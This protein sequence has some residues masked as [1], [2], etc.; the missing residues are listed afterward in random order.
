MTSHSD[1][2]YIMVGSDLDNL[3]GSDNF[4]GHVERFHPDNFY[5]YDELDDE[6]SPIG[7]HHYKLIG[8][9]R[10]GLTSDVQR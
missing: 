1:I 3:F 6:D 9:L 5:R 10:H 4:C 2:V 7:C 8:L